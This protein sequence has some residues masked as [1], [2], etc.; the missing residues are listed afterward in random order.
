MVNEYYG[1]TNDIRKTM[2]ETRLSFSEVWEML[3]YKDSFDF[4][5]T[6]ID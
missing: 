3:G 1:K 5:D 4:Y 6:P 2:K